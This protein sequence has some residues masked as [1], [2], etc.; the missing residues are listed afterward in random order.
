MCG[1]SKS[2]RGGNQARRKCC[3]DT[4][5]RDLVE[6]SVHRCFLHDLL[7]VRAGEVWLKGYALGCHQSMKIL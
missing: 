3:K 6:K 1:L 5:V 2:P 7:G 4:P